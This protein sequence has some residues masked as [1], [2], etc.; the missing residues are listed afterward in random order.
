MKGEREDERGSGRVGGIIGGLGE[1]PGI[2]DACLVATE[3]FPM[4]KGWGEG[5]DGGTPRNRRRVPP[6]SWP[7]RVERCA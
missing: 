2:M 4:I 5:H 7:C 1:P 6:I 3:P